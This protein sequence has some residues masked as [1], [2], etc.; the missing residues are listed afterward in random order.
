MTVVWRF[1][2]V[3]ASALARLRDGTTSEVEPLRTQ[4]LLAKKNLLI[5]VE[6][7]LAKGCTAKDIVLAIIGKISVRWRHGYNN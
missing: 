6:G 5:K 3:D 1:P 2:H 4:T 7:T